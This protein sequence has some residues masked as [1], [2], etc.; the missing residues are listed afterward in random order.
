MAYEVAYVSSEICPGM[1]TH[2]GEGTSLYHIY[3]DV[4]HLQL[5]NGRITL[6]AETPGPQLQK[7]LGLHPG[8]PV[9][10]MRC[11]MHLQDGRPL[12]YVTC[13]YSGEKY[14]FSVNLTR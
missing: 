4:Y 10:T 7:M 13:D 1:H 5:G 8:V 9:L 12:Y 2:L 6:E 11:T 3:E 14:V